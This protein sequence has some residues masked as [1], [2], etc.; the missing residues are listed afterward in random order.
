MSTSQVEAREPEPSSVPPR[1]LPTPE[2]KAAPRPMARR[3]AAFLL[4][5]G[6]GMWEQG[7]LDSAASM[8]FNFFLSLI[9]LLV[10]VGFLLGHLVRTRGVEAFMAPL[11]DTLPASSAELVGHELQRMAGA[12]AGSIAPLS[13]LTFFWLASS[14]IHHMMAVFERAVHASRRRWIEQRALA[15]ACV[16]MG[17]AMVSLTSWGI[18]EMD[19]A[20]HRD[21]PRMPE[22]S[23]SWSGSPGAARTP[24][25]QGQGAHETRA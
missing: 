10:L 9:P 20:I 5:V 2:A 21:A 14:G 7:A 22:L 15:L 18:F 24:W 6:R 23:I 1:S 12:R 8:A 25:G 11:L 3:A 17:L 16:A 4:R 13:A 19:A